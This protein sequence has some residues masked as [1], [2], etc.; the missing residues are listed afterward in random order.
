MDFDF[1][2][3][4]EKLSGIVHRVASP[5]AAA[6]KIAQLCQERQAGC[7]ALAGLEPDLT[8]A[9]EAS[10]PAITVLKE[11]YNHADLPA[12]IDRATVGVTGMAFA[13]A[14]SGTMVEVAVNDATRLVSSLPRTHIGVVREETIID[15]YADSGPL[16]RAIINSHPEQV[17]ISFISGPSR[18]GDIELKLTLG[19]HGPEEAHCI[20]IAAP[21]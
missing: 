12:A 19:V 9:I 4:F 8:A 6:E 18:T 3:R 16:I 20:I 5:A 17:V 1:T 14:Q 10:C 21:A 2:S 11:P 15:H 7:I 13:I